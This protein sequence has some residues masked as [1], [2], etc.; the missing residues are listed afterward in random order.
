MY[1]LYWWPRMSSVAFHFEKTSLKTDLYNIAKRKVLLKTV[2]FNKSLSLKK[3]AKL[4]DC[5]K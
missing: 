1:H 2:K 5:L 3:I 4:N